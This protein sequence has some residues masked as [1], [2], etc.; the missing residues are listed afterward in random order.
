MSHNMEILLPLRRER[1]R[2]ERTTWG[3]NDCKWVNSVL[4]GWKQKKQDR[5][6]MRRLIAAVRKHAKERKAFKMKEYKERARKRFEANED[7]LDKRFNQ[8]TIDM[9][10]RRYI[11]KWQLAYEDVWGHASWRFRVKG[12]IK[13]ESDDEVVVIE[14]AQPVLPAPADYSEIDET[15]AE[16]ETQIDEESTEAETEIDED[17]AEA[18]TQIAVIL[19]SYAYLQDDEHYKV[20]SHKRTE[21]NHHLQGC[22]TRL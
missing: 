3:D 10:F 21:N 17:P 15:D 13:V 11:E 12:H 9:E 6:N 8:D 7:E 19:P 20:M 5:R 1:S 2:D 4:K 18:E 16:A 22:I 14:M